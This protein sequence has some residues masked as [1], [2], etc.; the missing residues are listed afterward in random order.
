MACA[1]CGHTW[2]GPGYDQDIHASSCPNCGSFRTQISPTHSDMEIR[3]MPDAAATGLDDPGG[4]PLQDGIWGS[5][6]GGWKN[7]MKRDESFAS[8]RNHLSD[9]HYLNPYDPWENPP[10]DLDVLNQMYAEDPKRFMHLVSKHRWLAQLMGLQGSVDAP[11]SEEW[12]NQGIDDGSWK[13][14]MT[15]RGIIDTQ[16]NVHTWD[17]DTALH[18]E[19][20][21]K[22][23]IDPEVFFDVNPQGQV[24]VQHGDVS[25]H[26]ESL[27]AQGLT[28][29]PEYDKAEEA[30]AG[31][32]AD[33]LWD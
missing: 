10:H 5:T 9:R 25:P 30:L 29:S 20:A 24:N 28:Y 15:G 1:S 11:H 18:S 19:Y 16:G 3:N 13:P 27:A 33:D 23:R 4:N 31:I 32:N 22:H 8:T 12:L 7:R 17:F 26:V 6:D 21:R 14:G 2:T